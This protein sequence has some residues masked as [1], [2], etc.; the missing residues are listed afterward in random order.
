MVR[1]SGLVLAFSAA[2]AFGCQPKIGDECVGSV[3][4]SQQGDRLCDTSQPDGYCTAFNCQPDGCPEEA[5]CIGFG[6]ELDPSCSA[7]TYDPRWPRFERTF[8]LLACEEDGDCR[9]GYRCAAPSARRASSIDV[10][11]ELAGSKVCF[12]AAEVAAEPAATSP[13]VR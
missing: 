10:D 12:P 1:R 2:W 11:N 5:V 13:C 9:E 4:C 3:D 6:L 8:C 7:E